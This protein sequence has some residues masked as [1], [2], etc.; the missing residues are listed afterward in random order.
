MAGRFPRLR[1]SSATDAPAPTEATEVVAAPDG[2]GAPPEPDVA[3][4]GDQP[5]VA[6]DP[7]EQPDAGATAATELQ[8]IEPAPDGEAPAEPAAEAEPEGPP[9]FLAR[10]RL[11][12]RLRFVRRAREIALRDLGGLVFD[13]HRFGRDRSDLVDQKLAALGALDAEMRALETALDARQEVTVLR[14]PGLTT[15]PRCGALLASDASYCSSCGLPLARSASL[16][17][18][19][20]P[21]GAPDQLPAGPPAAPEPPSA[22]EP[23]TPVP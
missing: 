14:E 13:L 23:P 8:V 22:D 10:G 7:V 11:R 9:A 19:P 12:R 1:R 20:T 2:D 15:C 6:A 18:G 21:A 17:T 5:T 4:A 16:P 3:P